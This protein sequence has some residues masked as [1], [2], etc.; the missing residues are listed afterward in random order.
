[1]TETDKRRKLEEKIRKKYPELSAEEYEAVRN[2]YIRKWMKIS[3]LFLGAGISV[4]FLSMYFRFMPGM[5]IGAIVTLGF[6]LKENLPE[7]WYDQREPEEAAAALTM[8]DPGADAETEKSEIYEEPAWEARCLTVEA[9]AAACGKEEKK[10]NRAVLIFLCIVLG[11]ELISLNGLEPMEILERIMKYWFLYI[12]I[13]WFSIKCIVSILRNEDPVDQEIREGKF[14]LIC[15][16]MNDKSEYSDP[17]DHDTYTLLFNYHDTYGRYMLEVSYEEYRSAYIGRP[18]YLV[19]Q[20]R[21]PRNMKVL[22]M[23]AAEANRLDGQLTRKLQEDVSWTGEPLSQEEVRQKRQLVKEKFTPAQEEDRK[24]ELQK[25]ERKAWL[26]L[27]IGVVM[28]VLFLIIG[29]KLVSGAQWYWKHLY[30][31]GWLYACIWQLLKCFAA[32]M[33]V[34]ALRRRMTNYHGLAM[35]RILLWAIAL[36]S[37]LF[38]WIYVLV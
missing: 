15:S 7:P 30:T 13:T 16:P 24:P 37:N 11:I 33:K 2:Q 1:M 25:L 38:N 10:T 27:L 19:L 29:S 14:H 17:D 36:F 20:K 12:P 3:K 18:Y 5:W 28:T 22:A 6:Y 23:Y 32:E 8:C 4:I 26:R 9:I 31:I 21:G 35:L 34:T